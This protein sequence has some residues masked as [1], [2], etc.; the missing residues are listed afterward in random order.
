MTHF[1]LGNDNAVFFGVAKIASDHLREVRLQQ[2]ATQTMGIA[3]F[4]EIQGTAV[5]KNGE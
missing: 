1:V 2:E 4:D 3:K 5:G